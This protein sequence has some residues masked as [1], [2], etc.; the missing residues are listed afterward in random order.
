MTSTAT[1]TS[2][3]PLPLS[4]F[5][6]VAATHVL[7]SSP[8]TSPSSG[9]YSDNTP[10]TVPITSANTTSN[11]ASSSSSSS[12]KN[13]HNT[14]ITS[15]NS[16]NSDSNTN[17]NSSGGPSQAAAATAAAANTKNLNPICNSYFMSNPLVLSPQ[18]SAN[19]S[20]ALR[21]FHLTDSNSGNNSPA[22]SSDT[23]FDEDSMEIE[24]TMEDSFGSGK[25]DVTP[26]AHTTGAATNPRDNSSTTVSGPPQKISSI[27][28]A[29][30]TAE[31]RNACPSLDANQFE[32][33]RTLGTGTFARVWLVRPKKEHRT[34]GTEFYA[35]KVLKKKDG[36]C[37]EFH[38]CVHIEYFVLI[39][40]SKMDG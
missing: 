36:M 25:M 38:A 10:K 31:S 27:I 1:S 21:D 19:C 22:A 6:P 37:V 32:L 9:S 2:T 13:S 3:T 35:L 17:I 26:Q 34:S 18:V 28:N 12:N 16:C 33:L 40:G 23:Y 24:M 20:A 4:G 11:S 7:R 5:L 8:S 39:A 14:S 15:G 29:R 30:N